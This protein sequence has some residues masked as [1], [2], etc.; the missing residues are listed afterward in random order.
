MFANTVTLIDAF[1]RDKFDVNVVESAKEKARLE[2]LKF[3]KTYQAGRATETE[4]LH[5]AV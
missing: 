5:G 2:P 1:T 4:V 3:W